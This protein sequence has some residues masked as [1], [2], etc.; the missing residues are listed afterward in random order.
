MIHGWNRLVDKV[1]SSLWK[2]IIK[3]ACI[4]NRVYIYLSAISPRLGSQD[5]PF[6]NRNLSANVI[7][8]VSPILSLDRMAK[9]EKEEFI[10][11]VE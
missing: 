5:L 3:N 11:G 4:N 7:G 6:P 10:I 2:Q 1:Q 9:P 8:S